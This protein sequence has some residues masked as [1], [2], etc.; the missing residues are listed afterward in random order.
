MEEERVLL[1]KCANTRVCARHAL[2]TRKNKNKTLNK[3]LG[4]VHIR[5]FT[6]ICL[7]I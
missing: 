4:H 7:Y 2:Y 1:Y 3:V 6:S 5:F